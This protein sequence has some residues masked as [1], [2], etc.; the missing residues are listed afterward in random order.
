MKKI[1][2]CDIYWVPEV[3]KPKVDCILGWDSKKKEIVILKGKRIG[4]QILQEK[5]LDK[6][7]PERHEY[8]EAKQGRNFI[9]N[10]CYGLTGSYCFAGKPRL[11]EIKNE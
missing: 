8:I 3:G 10:L 11:M 6:R 4:K 9:K 5:F 7:W 1:L 2:V